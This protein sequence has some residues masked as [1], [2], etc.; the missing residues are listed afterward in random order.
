MFQS[1][2]KPNQGSTNSVRRVFCSEDRKGQEKSCWRLSNGT[3][4]PV[5]T[6]SLLEKMYSKALLRLSCPYM[7]LKSPDLTLQTT[8]PEN[9]QT[10]KHELE[11]QNPVDE[12]LLGGPGRLSKYS[13][14]P[15]QPCSNPSN[16]TC[17]HTYLVPR[18]LQV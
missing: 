13:D 14:A 15:Y 4:S 7:L 11:S 3:Y 12:A 18:I 10:Q 8:H 17:F 1:S 9:V 6:L 5:I 2:P 16:P